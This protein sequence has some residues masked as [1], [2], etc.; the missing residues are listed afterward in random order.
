[1]TPETQQLYFKR[2][3]ALSILVS[4]SLWMAGFV[5]FIVDWLPAIFIGIFLAAGWASHYLLVLAL[6]REK[7]FPQ[8]H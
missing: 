4:L 1:M 5:L 6:L 3:K 2:I 7:F 8:A